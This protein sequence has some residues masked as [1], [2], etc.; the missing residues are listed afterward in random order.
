MHLHC[1]KKDLTS[2][3]HNLCEFG[4]FS[5]FEILNLPLDKRMLNNSIF[6]ICF[7]LDVV[8]GAP[9]ED[10][11]QGAVYVYMGYKRGFYLTQ[12]FFASD[13]DFSPKVPIK[14]FGSAFTQHPADFNSDT[15]AGIF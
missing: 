10:N 3:S 13:L 11:D 5:D 9:F 1:S 7:F 12:K 8:I 15:H 14:T 2:T 4:F 6:C